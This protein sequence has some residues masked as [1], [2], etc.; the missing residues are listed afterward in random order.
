MKSKFTDWAIKEFGEVTYYTRIKGTDVE[1]IAIQFAQQQ[2]KIL[3][4]PVVMK[5]VCKHEF[6]E[7][8]YGN[9]NTMKCNKCGML[10]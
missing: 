10:Y 3:N 1:R 2:L 6:I 5:S 9:N 8:R 4:I 7:G